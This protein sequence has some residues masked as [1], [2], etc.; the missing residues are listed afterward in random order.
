M[1]ALALIGDTAGVRA[2]LQRLHRA[3]DE[4]DEEPSD[5]TLELAARLQQG[6]AT[7]ARQTDLAAPTNQRARE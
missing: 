7:S 5:E 3:L 2:E 1:H 4:L 6:P